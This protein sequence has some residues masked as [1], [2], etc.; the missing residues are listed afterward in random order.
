MERRSIVKG[1]V[2][3]LILCLGVAI[4]STFGE[5]KKDHPVLRLP[6]PPSQALNWSEPVKCTAIA[7]A[8]LF[9]ET[10]EMQDLKHGKL[11][12][13]GEHMGSPRRST[14]SLPG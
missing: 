2:V 8:A 3:I 4:G 11:G 12:V 1:V 9:E 7:S 10:R 13:Y 14:C 5:E 6:L